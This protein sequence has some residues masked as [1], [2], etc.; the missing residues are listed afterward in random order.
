MEAFRPVVLARKRE[1]AE[2]FPFD[3]K[4]VAILERPKTREVRR[5]YQRKLRKRPV[6]IYLSE[7]KQMIYEVLKFDAKIVHIYFGHVA[8]Q[9]LPFI[10][11]CPRPV[12]VSFH[13]AD[14]GVDAEKPHHRAALVE[15]LERADLVLARSEALLADLRDIGCPRDKLRLHR[16]GIPLDWWPL[17]DRTVPPADGAWQF[18]QSCRLI[19]KKGLA[20]SL[21]AFAKVAATHRAARLV[22][23]G[24][25]PLR[26]SL[27]ARAAE[28]G[29]EDRVEFKGFLGQEALRTLIY[30]SHIFLHPSQTGADG[31]REGVP[32]SMLE[33]MASGLP[34]IATRH[35]GIPEAI[36]HG[37]SGLLV[38]E[39]DADDLARCAL[40]LMENPSLYQKLAANGRQAVTGQFER[41][42]Q[43]AKL[44]AF[45]REV[46]SARAA[47]RADKAARFRALFPS[48]QPA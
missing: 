41:H 26:E 35:G 40:E 14:A 47:R 30:H 48:P 10:R 15:V 38:E 13:G 1:N 22:I 29:L 2:A 16:T 43:S 33:A 39:R 44:E 17:W 8:V 3:K 32:N 45:Y 34:V 31:N 36:E 7:A 21:D 28:L 25:G 5:F 9:L 4:R 46:I 24:E 37:R 20:V 18:V 23:A 12:V 11:A 27:E 42:A 19:E 6:Q